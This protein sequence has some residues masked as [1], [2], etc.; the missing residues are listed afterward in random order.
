MLDHFWMIKP[1]PFFPFLDDKNLH[2]AGSDA[3]EE[4][5]HPPSMGLGVRRIAT[6]V[7]DELPIRASIAKG[8]RT[9]KVMG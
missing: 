3:P 8:A 4:G 7:W 9:Q 2:S 1:P 6:K 5:S